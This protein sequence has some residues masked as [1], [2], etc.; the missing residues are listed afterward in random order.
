MHRT[1]RAEVMA[2]FLD[3]NHEPAPKDE[4]AV[5]LIEW[6]TGSRTARICFA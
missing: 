3:L 5:F 2:E 4:Y 1:S 6:L